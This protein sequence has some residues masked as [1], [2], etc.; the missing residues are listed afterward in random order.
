MEIV[1]PNNRSPL[2]RRCAQIHV[3]GAE[4]RKR[5]AYVINVVVF[6]KMVVAKNE[7][8]RMGSVMNFVVRNAVSSSRQDD[9]RVIS[10]M[11]IG[12]IMDMTVLHYVVARLQRQPVPA[13]QN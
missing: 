2:L 9:G 3:D 8:A 10:F 1:S 7:Y 11:I 5:F 12:K 4:I 6:H 13:I